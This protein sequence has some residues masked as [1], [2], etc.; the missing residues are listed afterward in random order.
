MCGQGR[1][2]SAEKRRETGNLVHG[3]GKLVDGRENNNMEESLGKGGLAA[4]L[5]RWKHVATGRNLAEGG[6]VDV[7]R[8]GLEK[9]NWCVAKADL[10]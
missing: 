6:C 2:S 4:R 1:R 9:E 10:I 7:E 3:E 8:E 5:E